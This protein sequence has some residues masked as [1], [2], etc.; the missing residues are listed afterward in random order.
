MNR[1]EIWQ[2]L[3]DDET[4]VYGEPILDV[5]LKLTKKIE[6]EHYNSLNKQQKTLLQPALRLVASEN[7]EEIKELLKTTPVFLSAFENSIN[8]NNLEKFKILLNGRVE[9]DP[10]SPRAFGMLKECL[11]QSIRKNKLNFVEYIFQ[12]IKPL[13]G[14]FVQGTSHHR[15]YHTENLSTL[16]DSA[17]KT[18]L[19]SKMLELS[20]FFYK[21][22][23]K[24]ENLDQYKYLGIRQT[25][26]EIA[27]KKYHDIIKFLTQKEFNTSIALAAYAEQ[28][29]LE[30]AKYIYENNIDKFKTDLEILLQALLRKYEVLPSKKFSPEMTEYL[31]D[32]QKRINDL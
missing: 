24:E 9:F 1:D 2:Q 22:I 18:T 30:M 21:E 6:P 3:K 5:F 14:S 11:F 19:L 28:N 25:I 13:A 12:K 15:E 27:D 7:L 4:L 16:L 26:R 29:D 8:N 23:E 20:E 10:T 32:L 31:N 17:F